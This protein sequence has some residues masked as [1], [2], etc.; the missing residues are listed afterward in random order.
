MS[1]AELISDETIRPLRR[2]EYEQLVEMGVFE[3]EKIELLHGRLVRM[4]PQGTGHA[5]TIQALTWIFVK[6]AGDDLW[7]RPQLPVAASDDSEPEPDLAIVR[8]SGRD[9]PDTALLVVEVAQSSLRKDR[10]LKGPLYAACGVPEYWVVN[11]RD[12]VVEVHTHPVGDHYTRLE[13]VGPEGVL[14]T[15]AISGLEIP[16]SDILP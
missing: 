6:A 5:W 9:H 16:V 15:A 3:G 11:L 13:S 12:R 4:T 2:A 7:V 1:S 10:I 8:R 14:T